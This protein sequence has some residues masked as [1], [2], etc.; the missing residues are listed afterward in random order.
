MKA[1]LTISL[2]EIVNQ[3]LKASKDMLQ[4]WFEQEN[5]LKSHAVVCVSEPH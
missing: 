1:S 5:S 2:L 4:I 3:C